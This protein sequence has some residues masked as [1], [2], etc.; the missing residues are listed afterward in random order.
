MVTVRAIENR[1]YLVRPT[2]TGFSA[3]IDPH[4]RAVAL[5]G[6][7]TPEILT[8]SVRP[9]LDHTDVRNRRIVVS[10]DLE[11]TNIIITEVSDALSTVDPATR[12]CCLTDSGRPR[13]CRGSRACAA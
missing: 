6:F 5:S 9:S 4:G 8:A 12:V 2:T 7:G 3:I 11:P 1:R 13:L 10:W